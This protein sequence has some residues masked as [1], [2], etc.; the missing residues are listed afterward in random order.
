MKMLD[1]IV[2]HSL[3]VSHVAIFIADQLALQQI[4]LNRPL[5]QAAAM[6]HDITKTRSFKTGEN[7][8]QSGHEFLSAMG[9]EEVGS[10]VGQH[11]CL[12]VYFPSDML[13]EAEIVNYAD[14][15]VLHDK[16]VTLNERMTYILERYGRKPEFRERLD[17]VWR[18]TE[19]IE[20]RIFSNLPFSPDG[21]MARLNPG[22]CRK[23]IK[24]Y[25]TVCQEMVRQ[26]NSHTMRL[27][28]IQ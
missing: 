9:F 10:I 15:R 24:K 26:S 18:K 19:E 2:A 7:H 22:A 27:S 28:D 12:N 14:K 20:Q 21:L 8:A 5:I 25:Q 23:E 1:H 6:L 4:A 17:W 11:V 13:G 16:V 3:W